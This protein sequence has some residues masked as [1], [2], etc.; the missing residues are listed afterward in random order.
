MAMQLSIRSIR[1]WTSSGLSSAIIT[2]ADNS[3]A[4]RKAS[5]AAVLDANPMRRLHDWEHK[6]RERSWA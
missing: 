3:D 1:Q 2:K 4:S 5:M 6:P